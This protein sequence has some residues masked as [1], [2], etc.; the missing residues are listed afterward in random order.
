MNNSE[1]PMSSTDQD[2]YP[3][4]NEHNISHLRE[5]ENHGLK[6]VSGRHMLG[7]RRVGLGF[8]TMPHA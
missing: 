5:K 7:L 4:G 3:P 1:T 8:Y 6:S 2:E